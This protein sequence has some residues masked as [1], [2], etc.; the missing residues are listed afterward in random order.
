MTFFSPTGRRIAKLYDLD[1]PSVRRN[2]GLRDDLPRAD[3]ILHDEACNHAV[4]ESKGR[5]QPLKHAIKQLASTIQQL[6]L[7]N[8]RYA[9]TIKAKIPKAE[10]GIY[11]WDHRTHMV[12]YKLGREKP[13]MVAP[14]LP[15]LLFRPEEAYGWV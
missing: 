12:Y 8:I 7:P 5:A 9:I 6:R 1:E 11:F 4:I 15:L 10:E 3:K 14:G 2:L 13:V